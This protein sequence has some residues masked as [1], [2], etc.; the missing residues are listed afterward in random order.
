MAQADQ[1]LSI[2]ILDPDPSSRSAVARLLLAHGYPSVSFA[3][4]A[5]YAA[6]MGDNDPA[7][8]VLVGVRT[9]LALG[10]AQRTRLFADSAVVAL[11]N[12]ARIEDVA[13]SL[14]AGCVDFLVKPVAPALLLDVIGHAAHRAPA[15]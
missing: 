2:G 15:T 7:S 5:A 4:A 13:R 1:A 11:G 12:E 3:S 14:A 6:Y 9:Y 8:L 10:P